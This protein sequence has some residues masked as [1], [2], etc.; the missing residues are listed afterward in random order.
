MIKKSE[1]H[2]PQEQQKEETFRLSELNADFHVI[3]FALDKE[4][5]AGDRD[6]SLDIASLVEA[7]ASLPKGK[8]VTLG[9]HPLGYSPIEFDLTSIN[10]QRLD[11]KFSDP[12]TKIEA[13]RLFLKLQKEAIEKAKAQTASKLKKEIEEIPEILFGIE[14][15]VSIDEEG[16]VAII[17]PPEVLIDAELDVITASC[18][19]EDIKDWSGGKLAEA[20][21]YVFKL[22]HG[23]RLLV[24]RLAHPFIEL[25]KIY[26]WDSQRFKELM[27]LARENQVAIELN[28][29]KG[30]DEEVLRFL[31]ENGN[32][33]DFGSDHHTF[34]YWLKESDLS[35]EV[36]TTDE[37]R[38]LVNLLT[39]RNK[40]HR[41]EE[42][43]WSGTASHESINK[44]LARI[45]GEERK[46]V[47]DRVWQ[48]YKHRGRLESLEGKELEEALVAERDEIVSILVPIEDKETRG[49]L[50]REFTFLYQTFPVEL[51]RL[52]RYDPERYREINEGFKRL[53]SKLAQS[54]L[55][56]SDLKALF[57]ELY[58]AK[59]KVGIPKSLFVSAWSREEQ[60][61]FLAKE[62]QVTY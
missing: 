47:S 18:H 55:G 7:V 21:E 4:V 50:S 22:K 57:Q 36:E 24:N 3:H 56:Y 14:A 54:G 15:N 62:M 53:E 61:A 34:R 31:V 29:D 46:I 25:R 41:R 40:F 8:I 9:T 2:F 45:P 12:A 48:L 58:I 27:D 10:G 5:G 42:L 26:D 23:E 17:P 30:F 16:V 44:M 6:A 20:L 51:D 32:W 1:R 52:R 13:Y 28:A 11:Q 35:P 49:W 33:L 37:E 43:L 19:G 38:E 59:T 60:N 39:R